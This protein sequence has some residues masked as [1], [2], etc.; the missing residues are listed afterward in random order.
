LIRVSAAI[1]VKS[2]STAS[3]RSWSSR[4]LPVGPP[5]KPVAITGRPSNFS[6]RATLIPF[7]PATVRLSTARWR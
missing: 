1:R 7:P 2:V 6:A 4:R 3:S 5:A